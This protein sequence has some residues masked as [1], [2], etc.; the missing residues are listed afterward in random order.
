[1][2]TEKSKCS[3][4]SYGRCFLHAPLML[5]LPPSLWYNGIMERMLGRLS[6]SLPAGLASRLSDLEAPTVKKSLLRREVQKRQILRLALRGLTAKQTSEA[7]GIGVYTVRAWYADP[8][9]R[10]VV[11]SKVEGALAYADETFLRQN[12]TLHQ[13]IAEKS[14]SAFEK[15]CEM[16]DSPNVSEGLRLRVC[17]DFL[18][19]NPEAAKHSS[20]EHE[21]MHRFSA[22]ELRNAAKTASEMD[23]KT[24]RVAASNKVIE[25]TSA[26]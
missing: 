1:M 5:A 22:E 17:Q 3:L 8:E 9:F 14:E 7:L 6:I 25:I 16:M 12:K 4:L 23:L 24:P 13:K 10:R 19:R 15:M 18:D 20:V 21:H 26:L 2:K 11:L